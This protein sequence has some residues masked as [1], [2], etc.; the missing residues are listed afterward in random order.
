MTVAEVNGCKQ[1]ASFLN[2]TKK[3]V[4]EVLQSGNSFMGVSLEII[5]RAENTICVCAYTSLGV[6]RYRTL[7]ECAKTYG[8]SRTR[9]LRLIENGSTADDGITTF[10]F[11]L[12]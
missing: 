2:W 5:S 12:K 9:L 7:T 10:D 1:V 3:Q 4:R 8:I 11:P 6:E